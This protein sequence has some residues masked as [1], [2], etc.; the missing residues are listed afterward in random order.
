M[1]S[2]KQRLR[3]LLERHDARA[4]RSLGQN[5]LIDE[6][7][8]NRIADIA[9]EGA[10]TVIEIGPGPGTLTAALLE[11]GVEVIAI[12]KDRAMI[13][14]LRESLAAHPHLRVIESDVL[15]VAFGEL[16]PDR[17]HV[18]GNIPYNISAPLLLELRRQRRAIGPT[19]LMLQK[20][21]ADRIASPPGQKSYGSLSVM[22]QSFA[23]IERLIRVPPG[24]FS[25][26]PKV[27]STVVRMRWLEHPRAP[28]EDEAH[29]ERV[30]R[31]AFA[32]RR[33]MLRNSLRTGFD[34]ASVERAG[35]EAQIALDRRAETLTLAEF[36]A[37]A[38]ALL[39]PDH[40]RE[41]R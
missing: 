13:G 26:A 23:D 20:E 18:A 4:K 12:E 1:S 14:I 33:K 19:T 24:A 3:A 9:S 8:L 6:G 17:P 10:R 38:A 37:L 30:V 35:E 7:I 11:R 22:L 25:P 29:F 21:V 39:E 28:I 32:Q 16:D 15:A 2:L 31:A 41:R 27:D 36:A 40:Q 5:F 34:A